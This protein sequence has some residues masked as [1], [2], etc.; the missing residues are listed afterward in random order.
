[1]LK[2]EQEIMAEL[3]ANVHDAAIIKC[4]KNKRINFKTLVNSLPEF[5]FETDLKGKITYVNKKAFEFTGFTQKDFDK[6]VYNIDFFAPRNA[7][8]H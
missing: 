2:L 6:G 7:K 8:E 3:I 5:V 4:T 1:M